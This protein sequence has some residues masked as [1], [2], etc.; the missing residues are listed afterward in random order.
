MKFGYNGEVCLLKFENCIFLNTYGDDE[1]FGSA[2]LTESNTNLNTNDT[3]EVSKNDDGIVDMKS[4]PP[5]L[6][7][8]LM[9]E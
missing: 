3:E 7:T 5:P 4:L 9:E 1:D 8:K 2:W 6:Q